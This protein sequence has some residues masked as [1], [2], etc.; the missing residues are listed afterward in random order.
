MIVLI[1]AATVVLVVKFL[2]SKPARIAVVLGAV[3]VVFGVL[4]N[5]FT[6]LAP[7]APSP[8]ATTVTEPSAEA[9]DSGAPGRP[10]ITQSHAPKRT[11]Y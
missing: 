4:P 1:T 11:L 10:T 8:P 6:P 2:A 3:A 9:G 5:L 7:P